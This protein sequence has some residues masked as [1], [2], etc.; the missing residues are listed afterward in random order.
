VLYTLVLFCELADDNKSRREGVYN[1]NS[2]NVLVSDGNKMVGG[3]S[4][5]RQQAY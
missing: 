4:C 5:Y 3:T 1:I 2:F